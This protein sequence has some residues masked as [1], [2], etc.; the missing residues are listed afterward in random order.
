V[1]FNVIEFPIFDS[2]YYFFIFFIPIILFFVFPRFLRG[3]VRG[4][5]WMM[6]RVFF[7]SWRFFDNLDWVPQLR[8]RIVG[9]TDDH[10]YDIFDP[11]PRTLSTIF[12]NP[13]GNFRM[14]A[15]SLVEQ[16]S[17]DMAE[18]NDDSKVENLISYQLVKQLVEFRMVELGLAQEGV[19]YQ[20]RLDS[21]IPGKSENQNDDSLML[22]P[23]ILYLG[24][25]AAC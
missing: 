11:E 14:A 4:R 19:R 16:F 21:I 25:K 3:Q 23:V 7:P 9:Q 20:F 22:S 8:F 24:A 12:L 10:W 5:G 2:R 18:V 6:L 17:N 13:R 15:H 1:V